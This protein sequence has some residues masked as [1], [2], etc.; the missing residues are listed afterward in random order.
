MASLLHLSVHLI[1]SE[2]K[3]ATAVQKNHYVSHY[4]YG[5]ETAEY[6]KKKLCKVPL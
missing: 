3:L 6:E 2:N 4:I 5:F 1:V